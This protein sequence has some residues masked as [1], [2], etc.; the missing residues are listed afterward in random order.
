MAK[1]R[2]TPTGTQSRAYEYHPPTK[3]QKKEEWIKNSLEKQR[4]EKADSQSYDAGTTL[5]KNTIAP[6]PNPVYNNPVGSAA[7]LNRSEAKINPY[8]NPK[9]PF[10]GNYGLPQDQSPTV[11][12]YQYNWQH[13]STGIVGNT[14]TAKKPVYNYG[15]PQDQ[16]PTVQEYNYN[17]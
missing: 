5:N 4:A 8:V 15:L 2:G 6:P 13:P 11:Q 16:S 14:P 12:E 7:A 10:S 1:E 9:S 3:D 17:L